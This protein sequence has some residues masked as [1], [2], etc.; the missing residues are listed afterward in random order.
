MKYQREKQNHKTFYSIDNYIYLTY[1][2]IVTMAATDTEPKEVPV[3]SELV[4]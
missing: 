4:V 3:R 2:S 1:P